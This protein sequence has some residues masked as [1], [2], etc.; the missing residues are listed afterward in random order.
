MD[1]TEYKCEVCRFKSK[2]EATTPIIEGDGYDP[3][4]NMIYDTWRCPTCN[5][6]YEMDF[7]E[8]NYCPKCGQHIDWSAKDEETNGIRDEEQGAD[9]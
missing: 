7:E 8:Y 2:A 1:I 4:G 9:N 5:N 3:E 6:T